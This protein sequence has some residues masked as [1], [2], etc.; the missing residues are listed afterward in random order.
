MP[1]R[2]LGDLHMDPAQPTPNVGDGLLL[3]TMPPAAIDQLIRL[4]GP[5][6]DTPLL[7][8]EI[9]QIGGEMRRGGP[10]RGALAA[11]DAEYTLV[12]AGVVTGPESA[13]AVAR[14]VR[15]MLAAMTPWAARQMYLN[16]VASP[17]L[18]D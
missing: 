4:A 15:S 10:D 11:I 14:S 8:V 13:D 18:L 6:A 17:P 16:R 2:E 7:T 3:D 5:G 1:E 12:C 9:R